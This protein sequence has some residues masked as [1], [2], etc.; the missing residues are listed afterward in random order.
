MIVRPSNNYGP[1]QHQEKFI[2]KLLDCLNKNETFP[3]YGVGDQVREW[4]FV[5]DTAKIIRDIITSTS[6]RWN[7]IYNLS[8]GISF[9]NVETA[10]KIVDAYNKIKNKDIDVKDVLKISKD[11]PGHDRRY[12]ISSKK[13]NYFVDTHYTEFQLGIEKTILDH[14]K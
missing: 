5:E 11:R 1:K 6:I 8:S 9:T 4:T 14:V 2:P 13:L 3:L 7:E 10:R 12:W